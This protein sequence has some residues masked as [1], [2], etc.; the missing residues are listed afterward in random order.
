MMV[1]GT[2]ITVHKPHM[3]YAY[4]CAKY[5]VADNPMLVAIYK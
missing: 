2:D 5:E 4:A 1:Q 3:S